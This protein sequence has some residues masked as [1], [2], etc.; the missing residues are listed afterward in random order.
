[1]AK[2]KFVLKK[3]EITRGFMFDT[4]IFDELMK[5]VIVSWQKSFGESYHQDCLGNP[6]KG[7]KVK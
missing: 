4:N 7:K 5:N 3:Q 2:I 6:A 1:M